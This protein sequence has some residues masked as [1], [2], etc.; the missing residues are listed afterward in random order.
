MKR[1]TV[2]LGAHLVHH[3]DGRMGKRR[4]LWLLE[5]E[6]CQPIRG[7]GRERTLDGYAA[8]KIVLRQQHL[9]HAAAPE[10]LK[11]VIL[12]DRSRGGGF[13]RLG[14]AFIY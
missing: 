5:H 1:E 13:H 8:A 12:A 9:A 2:F 6:P 10:H 14:L 7:S 11:D 4:R 3:G